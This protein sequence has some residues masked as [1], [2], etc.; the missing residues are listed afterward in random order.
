MSE[1]IQVYATGADAE[2]I[3]NAIEAVDGDPELPD[4]DR[5]RGHVAPGHV[6]TGEALAI[7]AEAY[8]GWSR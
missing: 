4:V 7:V 5:T 6:S 3:E 2:T 8:T 1:K